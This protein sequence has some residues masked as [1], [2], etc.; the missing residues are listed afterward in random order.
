MVDGQRR[1]GALMIQRTPGST[2][3]TVPFTITREG[4]ASTPFG[5]APG[6]A[7]T[8]SLPA[9]A[10][11]ETLYVDIP[12]GATQA[13]FRTQ[14]GTGSVSLYLARTNVP[15]APSRGSAFRVASAA[16]ANQTITLSGADLTPGRWYVTPVNTGGSVATVDV[17]ATIDSVGTVPE[18]RRG[19]YYN[20]TRGGHGIFLYPSGSEHALLWYT[21]LQDGTP[22]WYYAQGPQPGANQVWNG[23]VYRAAWNGTTRTLDAIGNIVLTPSAAGKMTLSYN[24][25]GFTGAESLDTFLTGCPTHAGAPLDVSAH[26]Y[27]T[28]AQGYGYSVQVHPGY[29]FLATFVYDGIGVPRFLAAEREGTFAGGSP[30]LPLDQLAGF[31]PLGPHSAP[32]RTTVGQ[33]TRAYGVGTI[34]TIGTN[35]TFVDGVPGTWTRTATVTRLSDLPQGCN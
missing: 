27:D 24:I 11:H 26:W 21:Y 15:A 17:S 32:D 20:P 14:N 13:T 31:A 28:S 22:T 2:A 12:P 34:Q 19:S 10:A 30:N 6:V 33:L 8:V 7:R 16:G 25:D 23:T 5:L 1:V 3:I 35:A 29:E 18:L 9:S 4:T